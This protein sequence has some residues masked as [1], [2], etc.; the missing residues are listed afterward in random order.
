VHAAFYS[1]AVT[2]LK[3]EMNGQIHYFQMQK[4]MEGRLSLRQMVNS[5]GVLTFG[6]G[7]SNRVSNPWAMFRAG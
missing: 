2:K 3:I 5:A 7:W 4:S 1:I 6:A